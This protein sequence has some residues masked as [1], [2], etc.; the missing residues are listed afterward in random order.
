MYRGYSDCLASWSRGCWGVSALAV[1][2]IQQAVL[3]E[4]PRIAMLGDLQVMYLWLY[5][6]IRLYPHRTLPPHGLHAEELVYLGHHGERSG[7]WRVIFAFGK[8]TGICKEEDLEENELGV[9]RND[10]FVGGRLPRGPAGRFQ[11]VGGV[12]TREALPLQRNRLLGEHR[13]HMCH[14]HVPSLLGREGLTHLLPKEAGC[15]RGMGSP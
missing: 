11:C 10:S 5:N 7:G 9:K 3:S 15:V 4:V 8:V 12:W 14:S 13:R 1:L 6:L 2:C